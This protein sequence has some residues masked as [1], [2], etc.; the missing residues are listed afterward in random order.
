MQVVDAGDGLSLL[1]GLGQ[2]RQQ[3]CR[4][5]G[6][7]G[8]YHE[9]LDQSETWRGSPTASAF[10]SSE[11]P[12]CPAKTARSREAGLVHFEWSPGGAAN[13]SDRLLT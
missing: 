13:E 4:Q 11:E 2:R 3:Q 12:G 6:N 9:K 1:F 5:N 10:G 8:D 7:N